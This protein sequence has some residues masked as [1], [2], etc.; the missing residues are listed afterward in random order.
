M[1][2]NLLDIIEPR[3][4]VRVISQQA[5]KFLVLSDPYDFERGKGSVKRRITPQE[6]RHSIQ[7]SGFKLIHGTSK[8]TYILW[9]LNVN[10]RLRLNYKVDLIVGKKN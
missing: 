6:L 1:A 8:P 7:N 3:K 5:K 9:K 4:L 10:P 2:L